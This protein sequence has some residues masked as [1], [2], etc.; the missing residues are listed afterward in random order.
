MRLAVLTGQEKGQGR[1]MRSASPLTAKSETVM[2][3][4]FTLP[5]GGQGR[6]QR[7]RRS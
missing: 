3:P 6:G 2:T 7:G 5:M 1:E 4:L